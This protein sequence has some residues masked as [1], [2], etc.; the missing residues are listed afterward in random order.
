MK[1]P[2]ILE[3]SYPEMENI[4]LS[5]LNKILHAYPVTQ[6]FWVAYSGGLDSHVLLHALAK[7]RHN[8][9]SF[10]IN[11]IHIHHGLHPNA[12]QWATHCQQVCKALAIPCEIIRV[13]VGTGPRES[14]EA[15]ARTARYDAIAQMIA[16]DDVVFTAQHADDQAETVLLQLLR[17]AGVAGLAAMPQVSRL[18]QGWLIRP[19]LDYTRDQLHDYAQK[20]QLHWIEDSSNH[21]TRFARNFLRHEIMPLLQQRW[22]SVSQVLSRVAHHQAQ[23]NELVQTLAQ[24]DLVICQ[25]RTPQQ[26]DLLALSS[27]PLERQR[28]VLRFWIKQM[29]LPLPSTIQLEHILNDM[30]TAKADRQ[31]MVRWSGAEVRRYRHHLFAMPNLPPVP[32]PSFSLSWKLPQSLSLPLGDLK[33]EQIPGQGFALPIGTELQIRFRQGGEIFY[34]HGHRRTVKKLL[35]DKQLPPWQRYFIPLI[36]LENQ[37]IAIPNIGITDQFVATGKKSG[38]QIKWII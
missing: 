28:N 26:L 14:V 16:P 9:T 29:G 4:L 23:A 37:L 24:Q 38:W 19:F 30:I 21:D 33:V 13:K 11:A 31:P 3:I 20:A 6:C 7:L 35:Q 12:D 17:G 8:E 22:P 15:N 10:Q 5:H 32:K 1:S 34:W 18:A 2:V 27:L 36:Y 25:G